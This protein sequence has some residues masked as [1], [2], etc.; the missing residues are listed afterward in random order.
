MKILV[1][2]ATGFVGTNLI[3]ELQK[4]QA[5]SLRCLVYE[6][7]NPFSNQKIEVFHGNMSDKDVLEKI[8]KDVDVIVHLAGV[9]KTKNKKQYR[10]INVEGTKNLVNAAMKNHA[11]KIIFFSSIL[12]KE[13]NDLYGQ[14]KLM[15]EEFIKNSGM[16]Y[17]IFR[18]SLIYGKGDTKNISK[19]ID[20]IKKSPIIPVWGDGNYQ[21]QPVYIDD[22][23]KAVIM[24]L[25]E[26]ITDNKIYYLAGGSSISFNKLIDLICRN[27]DKKRLKIHI[28][29]FL[30]K[31][32]IFI[33]QFFSKNPL[34]TT[35]QLSYL[36][37]NNTLD[38][39]QIKNDL[40]M[41]LIS[42]EQGIGLTIK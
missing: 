30:I 34:I 12:I 29:L 15:A 11:K 40:N 24:S 4:K 41:D 20:L 9:I 21:M 14:S 25:D 39:S 10:E 31:P 2:G 27:L 18:L 5:Y 8:T 7:N 3:L 22:V 38:T 36:V 13:K 42:P 17:T 19:L 33:Y 26:K 16:N 37:K 6:N 23:V 32:V 28:P 1:T 35:Q